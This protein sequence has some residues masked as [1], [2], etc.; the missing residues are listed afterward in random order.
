MD[1]KHIEKILRE[2]LFFFPEHIQSLRDCVYR[3]V[4]IT[5]MD[6]ILDNNAIFP[7]DKE[8][9]KN[10]KCGR[11]VNKSVLVRI[12]EALLAKGK[13]KAANGASIPTGTVTGPATEPVTGPITFNT[14]KSTNKPNLIATS[15][16]RQAKRN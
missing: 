4:P 3:G 12:A 15:L 1:N 9:L 13:E 5:N 7:A 8:R 14:V 11:V 16:F 6:R 10:L 2:N